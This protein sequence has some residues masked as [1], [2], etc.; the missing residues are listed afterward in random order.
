MTEWPFDWD[1]HNLAKC[2]ARVPRVD[3]ERLFGDPATY[4]AE[5]P[6]MSETRYR[7]MTQRRR[8]NAVCR[9]HIVANRR[10]LIYSS[11]Q[12]APRP[13][14]GR[15]E[16]A[17]KLKPFPKFAS[18][19]EAERYVET[20]DLSQYDLMAGAL[21]RDQ[22]F[23]QAEELYKDA[24]I[25]RPPAAGGRRCIQRQGRRPQHALSAAHETAAAKGAGNAVTCER[26]VM[27]NA[28]DRFR[29]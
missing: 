8:P 29:A 1:E 5:D 22:W 9:L 17:N 23:A 13:S 4:L 26:R 11:N 18:D 15:R 20:T 10:R 3:I 21:P 28:I 7:A 27:P 16:M 6:H 25:T 19:A 12:P 2:V 24:R 14:E